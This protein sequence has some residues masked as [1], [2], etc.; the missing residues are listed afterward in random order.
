LTR[1][2]AAGAGE[3]G[4]AA[5]HGMASTAAGVAGRCAPERVLPSGSQWS[6]RLAVGAAKVWVI[7]D[8]VRCYRGGECARRTRHGMPS[9]ESGVTGWCIPERVLPSGSLL[10]AV[11][12][13]KWVMQDSVR[14][15]R[16]GECARRTRH[17]MPSTESG[18]SGAHLLHGGL[19]SE[20]PR[21]SAARSFPWRKPVSAAAQIHKFK[22][23]P[24][25]SSIAEDGTSVS[26]EV[27]RKCVMSHH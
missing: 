1:C 15:Y 8:S 6:V 11:G 12:A 18:V 21:R 3:C 2:A 4:R 9:T 26:Y 20:S 14:C 17:G 5:R 13:K 23:E 16:G 7:L 25:S 19:L 24:V 27:L 10:L 22:V